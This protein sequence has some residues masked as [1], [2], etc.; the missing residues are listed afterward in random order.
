MKNESIK[1]MRDLLL[2]RR[3][4]RDED[5]TLRPNGIIVDLVKESRYCDVIAVGSKVNGV[6]A[7]DRIMLMGE[8]PGGQD[9]TF[10]GEQLIVMRE[11]Y[12]FG[13]ME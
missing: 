4:E 1:M 5:T 8:T 7:G 12:V 9:F 6:V 10:N 2:V 11:K 13:V 3:L